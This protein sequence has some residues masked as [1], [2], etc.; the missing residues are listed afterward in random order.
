M[1]ITATCST[2]GMHHTFAQNK[3]P[4][5]VTSTKCRKCGNVIPLHVNTPIT[6]PPLPKECPK[7]G[8]LHQPQDGHVSE[9]ECPR[10]GVIYEKYAQR[11]GEIL[12]AAILL[13]IAGDYL[14]RTFPWG[15]NAT[16]F[17]CL[18]TGIILWEWRRFQE[19]AACV[20]LLLAGCLLCLFLAWRD[21]NA[22]KVLN[23]TGA[24][25]ILILLCARPTRHEIYA[26]TLLALIVNSVLT[27]VKSFLVGLFQLVFKD[28]QW[29]RHLN[30]AIDV[31]IKHHGALKRIIRAL[32]LTL[33]LV[34]I[35][36]W[37]FASADAMFKQLVLNWFDWSGRNIHDVLYHLV[38]IVI[39]FALAATVLK[40]LGF[41]PYW[42]TVDATPPE[43]LQIGALE[44]ASALG[45]LI[46]LFAIF[47]FVQFRY[48]FGGNMLIRTIPEL[49][50]A[51]YLHKG[52]YQLLAVA[53]LLHLILLVGAW[54]VNTADH[55]TNKLFQGLSVPLILLNYFVL[56]SAFF[57]L[58]I[59]INA[60]GLTVLRFYAAAILGWLGVVFLLFLGKL[61]KPTW[62]TFT[63]AYMY[64]VIAAILALNLIN[65]DALIARI[66]LER[67]R[68]GKQLDV[69]YL[70]ELSADAFPVI[71]N[72]QDRLT[73]RDRMVLI[74]RMN[75]KNQAYARSSWRNWN[76]SRSRALQ[77]LRK[78]I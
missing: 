4:H 21:A 29:G 53:A 33:P 69:Q 22:L 25:G 48:W 7:C 59:Y 31:P 75:R 18:L 20:E 11:M 42:L 8:Y 47:I 9:R 26:G 17:I 44:V 14:L 49:T 73:E 65:P 23:V 27:G 39:I 71:L 5:G 28:I 57:R 34:I 55:L 70:Q 40:T 10:C 43:S 74:N 46:T 72:H 45:S 24:G 68:Q 2:C 13:G 64:S 61:L 76:Y 58:H 36:T 16:L 19:K 62:A 67:A 38:W 41:G 63:G 1:T 37:L 66:N 32:L 52:F 50:Y 30:G 35:F 56:A 3:I 77:L 60:Y 12:G 15:I 51:G 54:L 6:P 78:N